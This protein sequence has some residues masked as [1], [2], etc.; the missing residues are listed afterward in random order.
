VGGLL[1]QALGSSRERDRREAEGRVGAR[2]TG[3]VTMRCTGLEPVFARCRCTCMSSIDPGQKSVTEMD[4]R[5]CE[6]YEW[7]L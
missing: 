5:R 1:G 3:E 2:E 7:Y 6:A 4:F